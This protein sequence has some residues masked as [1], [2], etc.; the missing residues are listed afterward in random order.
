MARFDLVHHLSQL[1]TK[2]KH[3]VVGRTCKALY[4][5]LDVFR[6]SYELVGST[7]QNLAELEY[8]LQ[9]SEQDLEQ[10]DRVWI[11]KRQQ[12]EASLNEA[13]PPNAALSTRG[14][15]ALPPAPSPILSSS[16]PNNLSGTWP[17]SATSSSAASGGGAVGGSSPMLGP[18]VAAGAPTTGA[19]TTTTPMRDAQ[20]RAVSL[21]ARLAG[22]AA[23]ASSSSA[24]SP[25]LQSQRQSPLSFGGALYSP[26]QD[27]CIKGGYLWKRSSNVR[28]DWQRRYFY[29]Q[30][31]KLFYQRQETYVSKAKRVCDIKLC[32]VRSCLKDT[33]LR[34][35]FEIISPQRRT[36]YLLQAEDEE[37][38]QQWVAVIKAEIERLLS[39]SQPASGEWDWQSPKSALGTSGA[40][41]PSSATA[42]LTLSEMGSGGGGAGGGGTTP[43]PVVNDY[44]FALSKAHLTKLLEAN[45]ECVDCGAPDPDWSSI[46]L[47]VMM[48]IECS[49]I[50]RS[51]GVHVS[52]VRSLTLDR[53]TEPLM[54]LLREAGNRN[55]NRV[56]EAYRE[57]PSFSQM[58]AKMR[59]DSDRPTREALIR[60]K[61][62]QR[63]FLDPP[64]DPSPEASLSSSRLLFDACRNGDM[65]GALWCLA[66]GADVNWA[67]SEAGGFTCAHE[68]A[69]Q[70]RVALLELLANNGCNLGAL[71]DNQET[72][73][74]LACR[75]GGGGSGAR[76]DHE[77]QVVKL[78]MS[79]QPSPQPQQQSS[80]HDGSGG[81][82][83]AGAAAAAAKVAL[84]LQQ[85]QRR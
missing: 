6:Q 13:I 26:R 29:I 38:H 17:L 63:R 28:K 78:L 19:G 67:N 71:N 4:T 59:P 20:K 75:E 12:L 21:A 62:E 25:Q 39:S 74:D 36:T 70:S 48:C 61:Y 64:Y 80:V 83:A 22:A 35:S 68:A 33:D 82:G 45:P 69:R 7:E 8:A 84:A 14:S 53:W 52:K 57:S 27:R 60:A 1:E 24:P 16:A 73:L 65:L 79:K 54:E 56:W 37:S 81:G 3:Q 77:E 11:A 23:G 46:S 85:Q 76:T 18:T 49:G 50:H 32:H 72:P 44:F 55:A 51:M 30:N 10:E 5:F 34:F 31:G 41:W 43:A 15:G 58:K 2:K 42:T 47:G 40:A 66:H 9:L